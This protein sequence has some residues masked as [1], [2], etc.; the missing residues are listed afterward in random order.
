MMSKVAKL[1][2]FK[3][4]SKLRVRQTQRNISYSEN[5]MCVDCK[6][7]D[8]QNQY[9][10]VMPKN[11]KTWGR[12]RSRQKY[13]LQNFFPVFICCI[14]FVIF[15]FP[16][17]CPLHIIFFVYFRQEKIL[18]VFLSP[19]LNYVHDFMKNLPRITKSCSE[20]MSIF[21]PFSYR[22]YT[23]QCSDSVSLIFKFYAVTAL[24]AGFNFGNKQCDRGSTDTC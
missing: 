2:K 17:I 21:L 9:M 13:Q 3:R 7:V 23:E 10:Y 1:S 18:L 12:C 15:S 14:L 8:C 5:D 24:M 11:R 19:V 6:R 22:N 4:S 16:D 20:Y